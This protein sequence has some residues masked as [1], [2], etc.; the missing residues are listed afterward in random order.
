MM[1]LSDPVQN[2]KC[3]FGRSLAISVSLALPVLCQACSPMYESIPEAG[4]AVASVTETAYAVRGLPPETAQAA[5]S[6]AEQ[7]A[8]PTLEAA[9]TIYA[10]RMATQIV[11]DARSTLD[12]SRSA[13]IA[14][15]TLVPISTRPI[16]TPRVTHAATSDLA[17]TQITYSVSDPM[18]TVTA[19][20]LQANATIEAVQINVTI[21][22]A[23]RASTESAAALQT[24]RADSTAAARENATALALAR[25][26]PTPSTFLKVPVEI[27]AQAVGGVIG[28]F[29][30]IMAAIVT[31]MLQQKGSA[32]T[33][34]SL[35][36]S[37]D[38]TTAV[39]KSSRA[40]RPENPIDPPVKKH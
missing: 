28:G 30:L 16:A 38:A 21:Q 19:V 15:A 11:I 1:G 23:E 26:T 13:P 33:P 31:W 6:A 24:I 9:A 5:I 40:P 14:V 3:T 18:L 20:L 12:A 37:G 2:V 17:R 34:T 10:I 22:A 8:R 4:T 32:P 35:K 25:A 27:S 39:R 7:A 29:F 36:S